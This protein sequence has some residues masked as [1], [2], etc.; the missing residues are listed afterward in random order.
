MAAQKAGFNNPAL[1]RQIDAS[2]LWQLGREERTKM[3][4]DGDPRFD[5]MCEQCV[6]A[7]SDGTFSGDLDYAEFFFVYRKAF[8][9]FAPRQE[10]NSFC[11]Y[12]WTSLSH[13]MRQTWIKDGGS[14]VVQPGGIS[15]TQAKILRKLREY[16]SDMKISESTL[17]LDDVLLSDIAR[18]FGLGRET[19]R[20]AL[21]APLQVLELD[22]EYSEDG[23]SYQDQLADTQSLSPEQEAEK[24]IV[25][26][27]LLQA[28]L[29]AFSLA[30]KEKLAKRDGP[31]WSNVI[32]QDI[33]CGEAPDC[34]ADRLARCDEWKP[35]EEVGC[36]WDCLLLH[37]FVEFAVAQPPRPDTLP[38]AALNP[39][40]D[41]ERK[42]GTNKI[43]ASYWGVTPAAVSQKRKTW[44]R[45]AYVLMTARKEEAE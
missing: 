27:A 26:P 18:R 45:R 8:V 22:A 11:G 20:E 33:R 23:G 32:L 7:L 17:Y 31:F 25:Q 13:K 41:A 38:A 28:K 44:E 30:E 12:L 16:L 42:P 37:P 40:R 1:Q 35:L 43:M 24:K 39:L 34:T 4:L 9:A 15:I 36:L 6:H 5:E 21:R 3:S 19:L 10:S 2:P 29:C 14:G